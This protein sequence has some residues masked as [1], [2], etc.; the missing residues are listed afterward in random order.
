MGVEGRADDQ[1]GLGARWGT[2]LQTGG[3]EQRN[4]LW[5]AEEE[6]HGCRGERSRSPVEVVLG[7]SRDKQRSLAKNQRRWQE[8]DGP[9]AGAVTALASAA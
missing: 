8:T 1:R 5:R 3:V 4:Q 2:S 7:R 9:V 6:G